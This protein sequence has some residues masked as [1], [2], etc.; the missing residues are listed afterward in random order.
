MDW[1]S[2]DVDRDDAYR[3]AEDAK[4]PAPTV[5]SINP[6]NG[7]GL[8]SF[9]LKTP[10]VRYDSGNRK[11][12]EYLADIQ[13]GMTRRMGA[14]P[15]FNGIVLKNPLHGDW[16]S[17]WMTSK[18]YT[19]EDLDAGLDREDKAPTKFV[20]EIFG[21][22]RNC[23][24]FNDLRNVGYS[25]ILQFF[26]RSVEFEA[27]MRSVA[28]GLNMQFTYPLSEREL[29]GI[30]K[31]VTKWILRRFSSDKFSAMQSARA[32]RRWMGH[33]AATTTKPWEALGL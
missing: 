3:A 20:S 7:H 13:R 4:L 14:D 27:R 12:A 18:P 30:V 1:V 21:E 31:S 25:E 6:A 32:R 22:G 2:F 16:R 11:P 28:R 8:L 10:V 9:L 23:T 19:L 17:Q 5:I 33:T 15:S 26:G 29:A 24:I